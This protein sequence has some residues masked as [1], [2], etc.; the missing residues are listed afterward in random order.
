MATSRCA[1]VHT[2]ALRRLSRRLTESWQ[3]FGVRKVQKV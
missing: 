3:N 1:L 2:E